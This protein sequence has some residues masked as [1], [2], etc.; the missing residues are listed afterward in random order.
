MIVYGLSLF[1]TTAVTSAGHDNG[2]RFS[3]LASM[4]EKN[5]RHLRAELPALRWIRNRT[6]SP[7]ERDQMMLEGG[8]KLGM[9]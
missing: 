6:Q 3:K 8:A 9:F 4:A 7:K 2:C 5:V 1:R